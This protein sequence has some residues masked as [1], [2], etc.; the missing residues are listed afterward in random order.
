LFTTGRVA[1]LRSRLG[2]AS[3]HP[4]EITFEDGP[5]WRGV[6]Q[7]AAELGVSG[8]T[9]RRWARGGFLEAR[10]V[11]PQAPWRVRITDEVR[12]RI[13]PEAPAGWVRLVDAAKR[14]GRSKQT[15]LHWV[16]SGKL[17]AVQVAVG[18]RKGLRI[19]LSGLENGL[20][21]DV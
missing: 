15:V 14:L 1:H 21:A 7:A 13:V 2:I 11:M 20:F 4:A 17:R 18:K 3:T 10:Q 6:D 16:Q 19:E 5:E 8:D 12:Q 9:I